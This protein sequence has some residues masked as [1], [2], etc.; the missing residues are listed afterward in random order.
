M[1]AASIPF[2]ELRPGGDA[3]AVRE[4]IDRVIARGWFVLGPE[5]EAFEAEFA[6]A[7]GA[8]YAVAAGIAIADRNSP[9]SR[10]PSEPPYRSIWSRW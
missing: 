6:A 8:R 9:Q 10:T 5:V 7:S 2:L 3:A 1:I 4:A